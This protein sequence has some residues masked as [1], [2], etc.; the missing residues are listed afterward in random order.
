MNH[1]RCGLTI[2]HIPAARAFSMYPGVSVVREPDVRVDPRPPCPSRCSKTP[3]RYSAPHPDREERRTTSGAG[4]EPAV[5]RGRALRRS[6]GVWETPCW[7][8]APGRLRRRA[9]NGERRADAHE[10]EHS[11]HRG[12]DRD[13]GPPSTLA[14]RF[15]PSVSPSL[16]K[17]RTLA[18]P[19][20]RLPA[21]PTHRRS[22]PRSRQALAQAAARPAVDAIDVDG[23]PRP[24]SRPSASH[25]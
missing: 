17:R 21:E 3:C 14:S 16:S 8:A 15:A 11:D 2:S 24:R 9:R 20:G 4:S 25:S 23:I 7:S 18:P 10:C 19:F 12:H 1:R 22:R 5:V 6:L 13:S